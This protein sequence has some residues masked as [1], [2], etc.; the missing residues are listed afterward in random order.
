MKETATTAHKKTPVRKHSQDYHLL[1]RARHRADAIRAAREKEQS[2]RLAPAAK[3]SDRVQDADAALAQLAEDPAMAAAIARQQRARVRRE[4]MGAGPKVDRR[5]EARRRAGSRR[6][7]DDELERADREAAVSKAALEVFETHQT[8]D[9]ELDDGD[10]RQTYEVGQRE[11]AEAVDLQSAR[12]AFSLELPDFGPYALDYTR[13]GRHLALGGRSGHIALLDWTRK[14]LV[15]EF[16]A[17]ELV[18]DVCWLHNESLVATAQLRYLHVY[19]AA[20]VEV[21]CLRDVAKPYALEFLPYHFLLVA[22]CETGKTAWVDASTGA[23]AAAHNVAHGLGTTHCLRQNPWNAVVAHGHARG[24]V[25]LWSPASAVPL[26]KV[27]CHRGPV[28][29][30]AFDASGDH[31]VTAG[32]D[33][34]VR[35]WDART[36]RPLHEY[37]APRA[38]TSMSISQRGMLAVAAGPRV[39]VW[40]DALAEKVAAPYIAHVV[41]GSSV[42]EVQFAPFEDFLGVGHTQGFVSVVV[43]GAGEANYDALEANP[44]RNAKQRRESEV[45]SLLDKIPADMITLNG[46]SV[47]S[48]ERDAAEVAKIANKEKQEMTAQGLKPLKKKKARAKRT[49]APVIVTERQLAEKERR[50]AAKTGPEESRD[51]KIGSAFDLF[52]KRV[53][54]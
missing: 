37:R 51:R 20:G 16:H 27:L 4:R 38:P 47:G 28:T 33:E 12:K 18:K 39:Q 3:R 40:R 35:V 5:V 52:T 29:A 15:C 53:R 46:S 23:T 30:L 32:A 36:M 19:N 8:G 1:S 17:R 24:V 6:L 9:L 11:I 13:S 44:Y 31:M 43:P 7:G 34:F 50:E 21:H 14:K 41:E 25:S 22:A 10:L 42:R 54:L 45:H 49:I 48:I 2:K 26:A